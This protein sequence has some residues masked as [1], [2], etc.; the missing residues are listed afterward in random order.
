MGRNVKPIFAKIQNVMGIKNGKYCSSDVSVVSLDNNNGGGAV[1]A[2]REAVQQQSVTYTNCP[3]RETFTIDFTEVKNNG[4]IINDCVL[5]G[6]VT[7]TN[8]N[9]YVVNYGDTICTTPT[10]TPTPT[11]TPTP[12]TYTEIQ[13]CENGSTYSVSSDIPINVGNIV[14]LT[15][16]YGTVPNGCYTIVGTTLNT[17]LDYVITVSSKYDSCIACMA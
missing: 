3:N 4:G 16:K 15:F 8:L 12:R 10:P 11:I 13:S 14:N 5:G 9:G 2:F 7:L 1:P 6:S 17:P